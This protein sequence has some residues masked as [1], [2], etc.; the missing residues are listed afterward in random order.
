MK[1]IL[2]LISLV[3]GSYTGHAQAMYIWSGCNCDSFI[4]SNIDSITFTSP[5]PSMVIHPSHDCFCVPDTIPFAAIDSITYQSPQLVSNSGAGVTFDGYTYSTI[6]LGNGQEWMAENLRTTKYANGDTIPNVDTISTWLNLSTG[7]W[8][9]YNNDSSYENPYGKLYNWYAITDARNVCPTGWHVPNDADW[10]HLIAS[11]DPCFTNP[12]A[13]GVQSY[14]AGGKMKSTGIQYWLSP[15]T[16]ATN[17]T[18]LS[19]LPGGGLGAS[20]VFSGLGTWGGWWSSSTATSAHYGI[21]RSLKNS[22]GSLYLSNG[23]GL[24]L[25]NSTWGESVR[26]VKN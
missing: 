22:D 13:G 19:G 8:C 10:L 16:N 20:N 6:I 5:P 18:G 2:I 26:C 21:F 17:I 7:A 12:L 15:N 24:Y 23:V 11:L 25:S 4:L 9:Y 3:L 1:N 14:I